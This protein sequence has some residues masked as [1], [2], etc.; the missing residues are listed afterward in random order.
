[1]KPRDAVPRRQ[2][3]NAGTVV[4]DRP[5]RSA[6]A[7]RAT[8]LESYYK[9]VKLR[10]TGGSAGAFEISVR[11]KARPALPIHT[12]QKGQTVTSNN[13][14][15]PDRGLLFEGSPYDLAEVSRARDTDSL[16]STSIERHVEAA[17]QGGY[18]FKGADDKMVKY[19]QKRVFEFEVVS[20][21]S[22]RKIIRGS[23][24][25][26]VAYGT[27]FLV[28]D[29]SSKFSSGKPIRLFGKKMD[30]ISSWACA[31]APTMSLAENQGG[32]PVMWQQKVSEMGVFYAGKNEKKYIHPYDVFCGG[33][34]TQ[35]GR[36]FGRSMYIPVLD[37]IIMLRE[38]EQLVYIISQKFAFPLVQYVIGTKEYPAGDITTPNGGTISEVEYAKATVEDMP[39]EGVFVTP[40][41]HEIKII[42]TE[43]EVL[44]L[45]KYLDYW[46][47]R[48]QEGCRLS[49]AVL[50][51]NV[52]DQSKSSAQSQMQ[53]LMD[54]AK[55][56]QDEI[57]DMFRP[58]LFQ[59][60][61]EGGFDVTDENMVELVFSSPNTEE[62]RAN[63]NHVLS[64]AQGDL[65]THEEARRR[66]GKPP[67]T[68]EE[69][70]KTYS[71][72]NHE[73]DKELAKMK[74]AQK[75]A[76]AGS[77]KKKATASK[78]T[79]TSKTRPT[80]QHKTKATKT[81]VK[82][83]DFVVESMDFI[84]SVNRSECINGDALRRSICSGVKV[85]AQ[86]HF[87]G[88]FYDALDEARVE[89]CNPVAFVTLEDREKIISAAIDHLSNESAFLAEKWTPGFEG[90]AIFDQWALHADDVLEKVCRF[91]FRSCKANA[92]KSAGVKEMAIVVGDATSSA[93]MSTTDSLDR[94]LYY[95]DENT[96]LKAKV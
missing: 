65:I 40:E 90:K 5:V 89:S 12:Y 29:R 39:V 80:N 67:M 78:K 63:E 3:F 36:V 76:A 11:E 38:L 57:T 77:A 21:T 6:V 68:E 58:F 51:T 49:N 17:L 64:Q 93:T 4:A 84:R 23:F 92:L 86:K 32:Q 7:E 28:V 94:V 47:N 26:L 2:A 85:V 73:R 79:T 72:M 19:I 50:G 25:N 81:K 55:Y 46:R 31:D 70:K 74:A 60:L 62:D 43:G 33:R 22:M 66:L 30:P 8:E 37:D 52:G 45:K 9:D 69:K 18:R 48:V 44:D 88:I 82:A 20:Q 34:H 10:A 35:P 24:D 53:G 41:R 42:G 16:L 83:N 56:L 15:L 1:M 14:G 96:T 71:A 59:V 95:M 91:A 61:L 27:A 87:P 54:S 75:A 13:R